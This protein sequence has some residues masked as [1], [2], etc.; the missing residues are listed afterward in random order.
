L[1]K[2]NAEQK[3]RKRRQRKIGWCGGGG[4]ESWVVRWF[5]GALPRSTSLS[6]NLNYFQLGFLAFFYC[7]YFGMVFSFFSAVCLG[8]VLVGFSFAV[9]FL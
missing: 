4:G 3:S 7:I 8:N 6:A 1:Y 5:S 2:Q 9:D